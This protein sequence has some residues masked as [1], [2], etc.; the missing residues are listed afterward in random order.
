MG[1]TPRWLEGQPGSGLG[2]HLQRYRII[3]CCA[4]P[5][6]TAV[7]VYQA[8]QGIPTDIRAIPRPLIACEHDTRQCCREYDGTW[9][10]LMDNFRARSKIANDAA[11]HAVGRLVYRRS[12]SILETRGH[13]AGIQAA[14]ASYRWTERQ[15]RR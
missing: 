10:I 14:P 12:Y 6:T 1:T 15:R 7:S 8:N 11:V 3:A 4:G 2:L 5:R 9:T 13:K